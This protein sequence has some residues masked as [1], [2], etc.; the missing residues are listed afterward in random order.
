MKHLV[1]GATGFIGSRVAN[2]LIERGDSV[3]ALTRSPENATDLPSDVDVVQGDITEKETLREP[4]ADVDSVFH[5][6]AWYQIGPGPENRRHAERVNVDGARNV[7]EMMAEQDVDRGVYVSTAGVYGE[8][9]EEPVDESYRPDPDLPSVYQRTKWR[10]HHEV[11]EPM[12][13]DGLPLIIATIGGIYGK[14]DKAYGGTPRSGI[15][16]Y[17][18][19]DFPAIPSDFRIPWAHVADTADNLVAAMDQGTPGEEYIFGGDEATM[20]EFLAVVAAQTDKDPP[21]SVPR[22][23]FS[24]LATLARG[25]ETVTTL[26]ENMRAENLGFLGSTHQRYDTSKVESALDID[27]RSIDEGLPPVVE[28]EKEQLGM[29]EA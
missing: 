24:G 12:I 9:G 18:E 8:T 14:G 27:H 2:Q 20:E 16:A 3:V 26:P 6:A 13:E 15:Q 1:T 22:S 29:A 23:V 17:L 25:I 10:A 11:A 7:F 4:M 21:L 5:L 28:W 19:G